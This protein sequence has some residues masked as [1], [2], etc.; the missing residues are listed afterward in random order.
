[1]PYHGHAVWTRARRMDSATPPSVYQVHLCG[2]IAEGTTRL[3]V[4]RA[5]G[6]DSST[7]PFGIVDPAA[8]YRSGLSAALSNAG[9]APVD[10]ADPRAWASTAGRRVLLWTVR[11][12]EDWKGFRALRGLNPE[13]VL[14]AL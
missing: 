8:S 7:L 14:V 1:M 9:H 12:V 11:G 3:G 10:V 6:G 5:V 13:L 4:G 2:S